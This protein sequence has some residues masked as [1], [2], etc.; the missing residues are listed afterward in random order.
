M[1]LSQVPAAAASPADVTV[2]P[3]KVASIFKEEGLI[4][5]AKLAAFATQGGH[6]A[7]S[8]SVGGWMRAIFSRVQPIAR[9]A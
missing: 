3:A 5:V 2:D 9:E 4:P 7:R 1:P 6:A 8:A